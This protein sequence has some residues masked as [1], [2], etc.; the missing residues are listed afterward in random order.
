[1]N[2]T[3][4]L[5]YTFNNYISTFDIRPIEVNMPSLTPPII[6]TSISTSQKIPVIN[7][8]HSIHTYPSLVPPINLSCLT[9]DELER[10]SYM[11]NW[12]G[13][14][15]RDFTKPFDLEDIKNLPKVS[16]VQ[17]AINKKLFQDILD[18]KY[19][20]ENKRGTEDKEDV[21]IKLRE[22]TDEVSSLEKSNKYLSEY[23]TAL[24]VEVKKVL[25]ENGASEEEARLVV[26][27]LA[28]VI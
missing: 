11:R 24:K 23:I 16:P 12:T 21:T 22:L 7:S 20:P 28:P 2:S 27:A 15:D 19:Y 25:L 14:Y 4:Q 9:K 5:T 3:D 13:E 6:T 17:E 8:P 1:M 18:S 10:Y 26:L